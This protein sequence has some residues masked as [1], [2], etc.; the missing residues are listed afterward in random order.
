MTNKEYNGWYNY[1]TW[2]VSLW[3]DNDQGSQDYWMREADRFT[4][5]HRHNAKY[6][7]ADALKSQ[8]E[9]AQPELDGF[10][11][12]LLNAAL[13]EVNWHEIAEHMIIEADT[14]NT[15]ED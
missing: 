5:K 9:E 7:L 8:Y 11:A 1:E 2:L 14:Q 12:D 15:K 10:W 6:E 13:S 3:I 4:R